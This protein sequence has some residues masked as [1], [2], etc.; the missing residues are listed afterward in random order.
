[1]VMAKRSDRL[2]L[3]LHG[4]ERSAER[5]GA[6]RVRLMT[7]A[8]EVVGRLH[9]AET[10]NAAILW[11]FGS[12]GGL[13]GPAGGLYTRLAEQF[14]PMAVTSL[15]LD[16]RHPG[17]LRHCVLDVLLGVSY[18]GSLG[19]TRIV[20]VGHSFGGAVVINA[21]AVSQAVIAVAALSSQSCGT[22]RVG[23]LSPKPAMFIHGSADEVLSDRCS[24]DLYARAGEPK[25][26][27]LYPGCRHG[28]DQWRDALDR[29]LTRWLQQV[30]APDSPVTGSGSR[31]PER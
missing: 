14:R 2:S 26:L 27:I 6:D 5:E 8:G 25:Q 4:V 13:G 22:D 28:L 1:M 24:R 21:G 7:N 16:Y 23:E 30:L 31:A 3:C 19:R 10:G 29:D 12:G 17:D 9:L 11:V 18:L 15:E 20:L